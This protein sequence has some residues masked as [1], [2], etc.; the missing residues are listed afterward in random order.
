[1][2]KNYSDELLHEV[3]KVSKVLYKEG[4]S[5][6]ECRYKEIMATVLLLI[7]GSV[8]KIGFVLFFL[9]GMLVTRFFF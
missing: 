4:H 2:R 1:M 9:L 5:A 7:L 3:Y 6:A 8:R